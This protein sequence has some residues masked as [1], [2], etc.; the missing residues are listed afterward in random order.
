MAVVVGIPGGLA[1]S[2]VL[3]DG[4]DPVD[5]PDRRR[6]RWAANS[7]DQNLTDSRQ[8]L[9]SAFQKAHPDITV[10]LRLVPFS[11]DATRQALIQAVR[12]GTGEPDVYLGD[13]IW[14]AEFA[15]EQ[16]AMPLDDEFDQN[17]WDR[18]DPVALAASTY[19][20]RIYAAPYFANRGVLYYRPDLLAQVGRRPPT[21]W[22]ELEETATMLRDVG[23]TEYRLAWQGA[24]YE[25]LTCVWTEFAASAGGRTLDETGTRST[26]DS[27]ACV[28]ALRLMRGLVERG[29]THPDLTM[30]REPLATKLFNDGKVAFMRGW[31]TADTAIGTNPEG[32]AATSLPTF[33]GAPAP[34]FSAVG[35]WSMFVN[36]H[37]SKIAAVRTFIE[38]MTSVPAQRTLSRYG[39]MPANRS[40][41]A[42]RTLVNDS[43]VLAV[44]RDARSVARPASTP[45][46]QQISR[47]VYTHVNLALGGEVT[48][49]E[50]LARAHR[51]ITAA[52]R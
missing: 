47:A 9:I 16:L 44:T 4:D 13:V 52:L 42:D 29:I 26:I 49:E 43:P 1:L 5:D 48:P 33:A 17:F 11:T 38:W 2:Q 12:A 46:Y 30:L 20:G 40:V 39:Q 18:F 23:R 14:P 3:G 6:I 45:R 32:Y 24:A 19:R 7:N 22:E 51:D 41:L 8:V 27:P 10:D 50:A 37:T 28:R 36:P 25:G 15:A 21:T 34:G 35:G 31:N